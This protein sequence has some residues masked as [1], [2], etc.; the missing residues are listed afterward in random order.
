MTQPFDELESPGPWRLNRQTAMAAASVAGLVGFADL[1]AT[2]GLL[3]AVML[4]AAA[5]ALVSTV[6]WV[7]ET[8]PEERRDQLAQL[9]ATL[10][11]HL[12]PW[13]VETGERIVARVATVVRPLQD[14]VDAIVDRH[15][16]RETQQRAAHVAMAMAS[17]TAILALVLTSAAPVRPASVATA[18]LASGKAPAA[19]RSHLGPLD[20]ITKESR[21]PVPV[22][23]SPTAKAAPKATAAA[24]PNAHGVLPVG[25]GMWIWLPER[26]EGGDVRGIVSRAKA[27]GITHVYVKVG[28]SVDGFIN[29]DFLGRLLPA[30][31]AAGIRVYGWDFPYLDNV[32]DDVNRAVAAAHFAAPG[33]HHLDGLS[34]DIELQSMG[35]KINHDTALGYGAGLRKLLG[36]DYPLI[37]TVPRPSSM[38]TNYPFAEIASNFDALAP[39]V[40]W[41]NREAG[42]DVAGAIFSLRGYGKPIMPIGQAYDGAAEGGRPGVPQKAEIQRFMAVA[43][44]YGSTSVSFWS[45]QH[46]DPQ[47]WDAIR[48]TWQFSLPAAPQP[49]HPGQVRAY[50]SLLSNLGFPVKLSNQL[51]QQTANAVAAYQQRAHLPVTGI[52]DAATRAMLMTPFAPPIHAHG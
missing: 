29:Q 13:A 42:A 43:E 36:A 22:A 33:G 27:V 18:R 32:G 34:A 3:A 26:A 40:Y 41:L 5:A 19:V 14:A 45:W 9:V 38:L 37:A 1:T 23:V 2:H 49:F 51:D 24:P 6:R 48:E 47:A 52:I 35:V 50:Q 10:D 17:V 21:K 39:M 4:C 15:I 11:E 46:A 30:A 8:L 28:S 12:R 16:P 7:H 20:N 44:M 31:H 25:K